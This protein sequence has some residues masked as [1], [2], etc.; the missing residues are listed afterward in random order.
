M[1]IVYPK[2]SKRTP[3][4]TFLSWKTNWLLHL[5]PP[6]LRIVD[7]AMAFLTVHTVF[8]LTK[9]IQIS[10]QPPISWECNTQAKVPTEPQFKQKNTYKQTIFYLTKSNQILK[11]APMRA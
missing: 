6:Y 5:P 4:M 10:K 8:N 1:V 7:S 11:E 2:S 3:F 9:L